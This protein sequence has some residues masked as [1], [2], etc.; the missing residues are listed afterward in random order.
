MGQAGLQ[1]AETGERERENTR[2]RARERVRT[3]EGN[4]S[5]VFWG[6][7]ERLGPWQEVPGGGSGG[8]GSCWFGPIS[9]GKLSPAL[10]EPDPVGPHQG[11]DIVVATS[12]LVGEEF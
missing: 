11:S 8:D 10:L 9:F 3:G 2:S 1:N 4:G 7:E 6:V 12:P 5:K